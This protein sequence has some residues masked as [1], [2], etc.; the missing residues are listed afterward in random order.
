MRSRRLVP[1]MVALLLGWAG[2]SAAA[3]HLEIDAGA[4]LSGPAELGLRLAEPLGIAE[5]V[6]LAP[7]GFEMAA[8][9]AAGTVVGTAR[10][11]ART[12]AGIVELGG[13]AEVAA[14]PLCGSADVVAAWRVTLVAA[15]HGVQLGIAAREVAPA[16]PWSGLA[17]H[18]I[19]VCGLPSGSLVLTDLRLDLGRALRTPA[20]QGR[21]VWRALVSPSGQGGEVEARSV[22]PLPVTL[23]LSGR[24]VP[25]TWKA[26]LDGSLRAGGAP[27]ASQRVS[28]LA[29]PTAATAR[30]IRVV[31]T[32]EQ[33]RFELTRSIDS[34]TVF[35]ARTERGVSD[36]PGGCTAPIVE[37]GCSDATLVVAAASSEIVRVKVPPFPVLRL[38]SSGPAVAR[39]QRRLVDLHYLPPG[40]VSGKLGDRT[41]H[42]VVALQGWE[43]LGRT[44]VVDRRTW[45]R[46]L[47]AAVPRPWGGLSFGVEIDLAR[48]V[49][50]L[51]RNGAVERAIHVSTGAG[52]GT[53][54][55]R[56]SVR[57]KAL[58]S[59]S[60]KF[61]AW[62]PYA[63]YFVGGF[64]LHAYPSVP[65]YP[66]SHGCVRLP[67]VEAQ[68]AYAFTSIGTP[69]WIR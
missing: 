62:L 37:G 13:E 69:V 65:T 11:R 56:F 53:P 5:A 27:V 12:D 50:L 19:D 30:R 41:W 15:G 20:T 29:G 7:H 63:Q 44:G 1:V 38:N 48:Q 21:Y 39:L 25:S 67:Y 14:G 43:Q 55:G 45:K 36:L 10:A 17:S 33:G 31:T 18:R 23:D 47:T 46:L 9:A 66:A 58:M 6:V 2:S 64:A 61:K 68:V 3:P 28:I 34:T 52:G 22:T 40:T 32:G 8:G 16:S 60:I 4:S 24:L 51:V 42:A 26:E 59:W 54:S 35:E 57:S 49:L